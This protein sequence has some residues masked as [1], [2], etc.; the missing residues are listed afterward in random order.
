VQYEPP[1][2]LSPGELGTLLDNSP[3]MRD[4]TA[5]VVDLAVKGYVR[6]EERE[7]SKLFGL[8]TSKDSSYTSAGPGRF[9][10]SSRTSSGA[11]RVFKEASTARAASGNYG[12]SL[13]RSE[14]VLQGT[15]TSR[16]AVQAADRARVVRPPGPVR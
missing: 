5:T 1:E 6:I 16:S 12:P 14:Q 4:V 9:T 3:D 10:A 15:S 8:F 11:E 2:A 13:S 7:E